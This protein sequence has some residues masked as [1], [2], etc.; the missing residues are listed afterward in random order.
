M[1]RAPCP[2]EHGDVDDRIAAAQEVVAAAQ[3][4]RAAQCFILKLARDWAVRENTYAGAEA[5]FGRDAPVAL[6][7]LAAGYIA[8]C[9]MLNAFAFPAPLA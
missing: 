7:F 6:T 9:A 5:A 3:D 4:E 1:L 2:A 8:T